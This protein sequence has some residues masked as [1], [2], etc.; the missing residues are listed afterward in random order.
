M[1]VRIRRS[2]EVLC[3]AFNGPELGDIYLDDAQ[4]YALSTE[5]FLTT[6]DEGETWILHN[7][8]RALA[9]R[10]ASPLREEP[11]LSEKFL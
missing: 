5:G 1:S 10:T 11:W 4:H 8:W 2:G 3:A 6:D 7:G 9:D